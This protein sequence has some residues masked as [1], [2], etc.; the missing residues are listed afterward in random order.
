MDQQD[1]EHEVTWRRIPPQHRFPEHI[2]GNG[3]VP[4]PNEALRH[5]DVWRRER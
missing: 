5:E 1:R 2:T 4:V 3:N